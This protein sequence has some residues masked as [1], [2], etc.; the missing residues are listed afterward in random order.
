M[1][2]YHFSSFSQWQNLQGIDYKFNY[3]LKRKGE[4]S[5][6]RVCQNQVQ[7]STTIVGVCNKHKY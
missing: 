6:V 4:T 3:I 7:R 2:V 5:E 1:H